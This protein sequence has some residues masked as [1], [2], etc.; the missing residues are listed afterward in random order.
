MYIETAES[1]KYQQSL[2]ISLQV[3]KAS[4]LNQ[5]QCSDHRLKALEDLRD[6][7]IKERNLLLVE[8]SNQLVELRRKLEREEHIRNHIIAHDAPI[9]LLDRPLLKRKV[10]KKSKSFYIT[11]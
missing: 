2:V 1:L 11:C 6:L 5:L 9:S 10:T 7:Q 3:D 4:L 8:L